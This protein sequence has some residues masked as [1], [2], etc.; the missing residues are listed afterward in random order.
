MLKS[1]QII[2]YSGGVPTQD[3]GV[4]CVMFSTTNFDV[5]IDCGE[6]SYLR[7]QKA[8]YKWKNLKYILITHMHPDHIGG[9]IPLLFYRKLFGIDSVLTLI[10]PPQL[11][12][13]FEDCYRH[14][15]LSNNQDLK[16]IDISTNN[17]LTI[18]DNIK[19][20]A[21]EMKHKISCWGYR[22]SDGGK[23]FVF[24]TDTL[25]NA[26]AVKLAKNA[27][28]LIHEATFEH[29]MREKAI[30]HFHTTE[31]QAMEIADEAQVKRLIL[32]HFSQRLTD[33]DVQEWNWNG[34][35]CI[36]FDERVKIE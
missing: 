14:S 20:K 25:P 34:K 6:G 16:W 9:L 22:I 31:I 1:F 10:G 32:T 29:Q 7:W 17:Q 19:I 24:I 15:G 12:V 28:I 13:Y 35:S 30:T 26:N 4:T 21:L 33:S 2:G 36:V 27:D 8:G 23:N 3:R 5:M 11:K 18:L